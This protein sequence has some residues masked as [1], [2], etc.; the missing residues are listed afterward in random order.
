M[1]QKIVCC[2][3]T[4][5]ETVSVDVEVDI[6]EGFP[7]FEMVGLL[8]GEVKEAKERV[9][10]SL[11]RLGIQ[12][13]AKRVT[14]NLSPASFRKEGSVY[15]LAIAVGIMGAMG[16]LRVSERLLG[17]CLFLGEL[18]LEGRILP[19]NG[20]LSAA[21]HAKEQGC[22]FLF[23]PKE[24]GT[25]AMLEGGAE[26]IAVSHLKEVRALLNGDSAWD[27]FSPVE[28]KQREQEEPVPD[29]SAIFG[30]R[31]AKRAAEIAAAGRHNLLLV[32]SPG[33]GKTLL[34]SG[35]RGILPAFTEEECLDVTKI[36][37]IAGKL[38]GRSR[39][40]ARPFRTPHHTCSKA[41]M[42]GGGRIPVP[43]EITLAHRGVLFLDEFPEFAR[44]T[45]EVLREPLERG[46]ISMIRAGREY[47]FP[48]DFMLVAAMN[49]C[50][51][52]Y[53]PEQRCSCSPYDRKKYMEKIKGPLVDRIDL[54][55]VLRRVSWDELNRKA[56][57][58]P[59]SVIRE[60]VE[61][62]RK[63]QSIRY[64]AEPFDCNSRLPGSV[65]FE[66]L[67]L[68]K[69]A[70][71]MLESVYE[72]LQLGARGYHKLLRTARTIADLE[73]SASVTEAHLGEA[74]TYRLP[75]EVLL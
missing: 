44:G 30:Q 11:G 19:V 40:S 72:G 42:A 1:Y 50:P 48:A 55:T 62:A 8:A 63:R 7:Y 34:A 29:Y 64:Q 14:V 23:V 39:I 12:I 28:E 59:S 69:G 46:E 35:L 33:S 68:T 41:G 58:E 31:A 54:S 3:V 16:Q 20:V 32:G 6:S 53:Y 9:R 60:R 27:G 49:A 57:E 73:D 74:V 38:E 71:E 65:L 51:C 2:A 15:D 10:A 67:S 52:G 47:R 17:Q 66:Y 25:E 43:G 70:E 4:A 56:P 75:E 26:V 22:R 13:P 61:N 21:I 5:L 45:L 37:S 18:N 36:Y 24:N